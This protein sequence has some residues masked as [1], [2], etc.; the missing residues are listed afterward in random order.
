MRDKTARLRAVADDYGLPIDVARRTLEQAAAEA[1]SENTVCAT[2]EPRPQ[3]KEAKKRG[4]ALP[5]FVEW[6]YAAEREAGMLTTATLHTDFKLY[7]D[8]RTWRRRHNLPEK[9]HWLRDLPTKHEKNS[10]RYT[11]LG[12]N[13]AEVHIKDFS[14]AEREVIRRY[15]TA[16][17]RG[18]RMR[19]AL[20]PKPLATI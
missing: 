9:W 5:D 10:Q 6:A 17:K 14:E 18:A 8:Y 2:A 20:A 15:E 16:K 7:T 11:E 3:W 1:A 19:S 4:E 13:P 12:I